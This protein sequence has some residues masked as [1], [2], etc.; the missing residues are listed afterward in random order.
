MRQPA[1]RFFSP[2]ILG[3]IAIGASGCPW[4]DDGYDRGRPEH[5]DERH[6]DHLDDHHDDQH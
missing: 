5:R 6:E 3:A 1:G 4:C 2:L